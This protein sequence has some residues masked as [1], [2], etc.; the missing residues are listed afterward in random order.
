MCLPKAGV[1]SN[2]AAHLTMPSYCESSV[3]LTAAV[4]A[5][6]VAVGAPSARGQTNIQGA[7]ITGVVRDSSGNRI[8]GVQVVIAGSGL[9][10][11]TDDTGAYRIAG[12]M[13]GAAT[14][15]ARRIGFETVSRDVGLVGGQVRFMNLTM[16]AVASVL[17]TVAVS[18]RREVYDSR[19]AGFEARSKKQVGH[20]IT[21]ERIDRANSA[22]LSDVLR[23][24]PGLRLGA[25]W[26]RGG[27][28]RIRGATC[29]P[30]V[31]FDG[32]PASAGPF[33][34]D[35]IDL[36]GVEGIEIYSGSSTIPP[37]FTGPRDLDRCGVIAI[38]SRPSRARR[39]PDP[40]PTPGD[41]L[42]SGSQ[43]IAP[44]GE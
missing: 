3:C 33:D 1:G 27:G 37:E 41:S 5:L 39:S 34:V 13:P 18:E 16:T 10:S 6:A 8:A 23:E 21:R 4:L 15:I 7:T 20:F 2:D 11:R 22:R 28:I 9:G 31:F 44:E 19:L 32:V 12:L 38:W 43:A 25:I 26:D 17:D 35:M 24:V 40:H 14:V 29:A 42:P 30:L 36:K